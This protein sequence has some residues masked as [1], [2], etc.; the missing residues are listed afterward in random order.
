MRSSDRGRDDTRRRSAPAAATARTVVLRAAALAG[1]LL[2]V[3]PTIV[4]AASPEPTTVPAG[5]P[6]SSGQG[7]GLVGDPLT[8]I[9]VVAVIAAIAITATLLYVR[10]TGG[11]SGTLRGD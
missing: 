3:V 11:P 10:A 2:L 1:T 4:H 9:L 5:D 8:A 6:R 7:P